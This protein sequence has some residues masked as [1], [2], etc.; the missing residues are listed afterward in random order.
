MFQMIAE[1]AACQQTGERRKIVASRIVAIGERLGRSVMVRAIGA[2]IEQLQRGQQRRSAIQHENLH[3][4]HV[5]YK[6]VNSHD[7][8]HE[9]QRE[10]A[11]IP[12]EKGPVPLEEIARMILVKIGI[13]LVAG[14][15]V[16][17]EMG[18]AHPLPLEPGVEHQQRRTDCHI[19]P[20]PSRS[21]AA[22]HGIVADDEHRHAE[23]DLQ[24]RQ[25]QR[26]G[27]VVPSQLEN[28]HRIEVHTQPTTAN[29]SG[30]RKPDNPLY[31]LAGKGMA[32][33][34]VWKLRLGA[35]FGCV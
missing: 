4:R 31:G 13:T 18:I 1:M 8:V 27:Q 16:M 28:E 9:D 5:E 26:E 3:E 32:R 24:H 29:E 20:R 10:P 11:E 23:P 21:K 19:H 33:G 25:A 7:R 17:D 6:Q 12:F 30:E 15:L 22:M 14:K 35:P 34:H 2:E